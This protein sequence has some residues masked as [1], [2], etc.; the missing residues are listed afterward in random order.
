MESS[1]AFSFVMP[2]R[3]WGSERRYAICVFVFLLFGVVLSAHAQELT[4][5]DNPVLDSVADSGVLKY[6]SCR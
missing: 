6:G 3:A 4:S 1:L 2:E 5:I